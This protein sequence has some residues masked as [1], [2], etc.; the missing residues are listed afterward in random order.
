MFLGLNS[1]E[2]V[3]EVNPFLYQNSIITV[4]YNH[5]GYSG[6]KGYIPQWIKQGFLDEKWTGEA[7]LATL[8]QGMEDNIFAHPNMEELVPYSNLV[9]FIVKSRPVFLSDFAKYRARWP[10]YWLSVEHQRRLSR[11]YDAQMMSEE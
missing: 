5:F 11:E 4:L 10:A 2:C 8:R 9:N 7:A 3:K 1:E 6:F